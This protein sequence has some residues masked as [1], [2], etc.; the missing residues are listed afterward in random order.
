ML[1]KIMGGRIKQKHY[2]SLVKFLLIFVLFFIITVAAFYAQLKYRQFQLRSDAFFHLN[3]AE[4]IYQN[5]KHGTV[6]TFIATHTFQK[7]GVGNFLFYPDVFLYPL[8]LLRFIFH[9]VTAFYLWDGFILFLTF[10]IS[11][12]C[13]RDY[14]H[15]DLRSFLFALIYGLATYHIYLGQCNFV[16]GEYLSYS[17]LPLVV[18]G[19]YHV[20]F[21]N[22]NKWYILTIGMV[23]I[24]YCH[25]LTVYIMTIFCGLFAI[26]SLFYINWLKES[27]RLLAIIKSIGLY[28]LLTGWIFIPFLTD[29]IGRNIQ[30]PANGFLI[31]YSLKQMI[32]NSL[33]AQLAVANHSIGKIAIFT[34]SIGWFF[35][36]KD[37]QE[38]TTYVIGT[39]L[40]LLTTTFIPYYR[41]MRNPFW[42]KSVGLIQFP[43]R[44]L[45]LATLF[46]SISAS[47]ILLKFIRNT[48]KRKSQ[49][50]LLILTLSM[51]MI[52]YY[53]EQS[54]II[55]HIYPNSEQLLLPK[56]KI[57]NS[58]AQL[59]KDAT[60]KLVNNQNY[61]NIF[62]YEVLYGETDYYLRSAFDVNSNKGSFA[63]KALSICKHISYINQKQSII[64]PIS[65]G[66]KLIYRF[67]LNKRS[68]VNLPVIAYHNT[69]V[70]DNGQL[71]DKKISNRGTVLVHLNH[72][73][74][75]LL[76]CYSPNFMYYIMLFIA[77]F[78]WIA[79]LIIYFKRSVIN[80]NI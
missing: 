64:N 38:Q 45:S 16:L 11:Y 75:K 47:Y 56:S 23:L 50:G 58:E 15:D 34:V 6:L 33:D 26:L 54:P 30:V 19:M 70:Y 7:T 53:S 39:V 52:C 44:L 61:H 21:R 62:D 46:L 40:F 59:I 29:Y 18:L 55:E 57:P 79:L 4:E 1:N 72:G 27:G 14:S 74:H 69:K 5:L 25:L 48:K 63:P 41:M 8:A 49:I 76:V 65:S 68:K 36:R 42:V 3:R 80:L 51:I 2:K 37:K 12:F 43:Y 73:Y 60:N 67:T 24:T 77:I 32:N 28:I 20:I 71:I 78:T 9:P 35:V 13:M 66:N 31:L 10:I 22:K 17:F